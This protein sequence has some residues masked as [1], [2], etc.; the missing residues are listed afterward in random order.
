VLRGDLATTPLDEVLR[1]LADDRATGRLALSE[2]GQ[3]AQSRT[4]EIYLA[5]GEIY[6][7]WVVAGPQADPV[8]D[9]D[10]RLR[11][12]LLAEGTLR[13][14]AWDDAVEAQEELFDWSVGE[15]LVELGHLERTTLER[16]AT[17]ELLDAVSQAYEWRF[18][19]YRFRRR[20]KTRNRA[21]RTYQVS[22]LLEAVAARRIEQERLDVRFDAVPSVGNDA[23]EA[24]GLEAGV[25]AQVDGARSVRE[26]AEACGCTELEAAQLLRSLADRG[27]VLLPEPSV[28]MG[29]PAPVAAQ[30][31]DPLSRWSALLDSAL[32]PAVQEEEEPR[33][34]VEL[35]RSDLPPR[36]VENLDP[37]TAERR[38]R[39]RARAAEELLAAQAEAEALREAEVARAALA[40]ELSVA[41]EVTVAEPPV[42]LTSTEV[43]EEPLVAELPLAKAAIEVAEPEAV[44]E[45]EAV[46]APEAV[47]EPEAIVIPEPAFEPEAITEP[48]AITEPE[49]VTEPEPITEPEPVEPEPVSEADLPTEPEPVTEAEPAGQPDVA[50]ADEH[51][52]ALAAVLLRELSSLGLDDEPAPA[53]TAART[54]R[55]PAPRH[56]TPPS[57]K[58]RGIFGR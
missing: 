33:A 42:V 27:C 14:E 5:A 43:A 9:A 21:G 3:D 46:A 22:D 2:S 4:A 36:P 10:A 11:L 31:E 49:A 29:A 57:K 15:L 1:L 40:D 34:T 52:P 25:L 41:P 50:G 7:A 12:R 19:S 54:P 55:V 18:G 44:A 13:E 23:A 16:V 24:E 39:L 38:A 30:D 45:S 17:Q 35:V 28:A 32:P 20:E 56:A 47:T 48:D 51:D 26:I 58:K 37:E 53:A 6:A 8:L